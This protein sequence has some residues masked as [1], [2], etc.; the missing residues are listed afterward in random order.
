ML[1]G[2]EFHIFIKKVNNIILCKHRPKHLSPT[3]LLSRT[4]CERIVFWAQN[5]LVKIVRRIKMILN[6]DF[7]LQNKI[8]DTEQQCFA[9]GRAAIPGDRPVHRRHVGSPELFITDV[10]TAYDDAVH[11]DR[12][13]AVI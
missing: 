5:N 6:R 11:R 1:P 3:P 8:A 2:R 7:S 9:D 4:F 10:R 13:I 12:K